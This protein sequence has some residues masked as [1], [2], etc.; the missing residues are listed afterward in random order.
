MILFKIYQECNQERYGNCKNV[1]KR[2]NE[3]RMTTSSL[4]GEVKLTGPKNTLS[5]SPVKVDKE[6]S[7]LSVL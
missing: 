3:I 2:F 4:L 7:Y 6:I 5:L 1:F